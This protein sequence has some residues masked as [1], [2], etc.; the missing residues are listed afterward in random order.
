M[1][2][3]RP[4]GLLAAL[5]LPAL[6]A[7]SPAA[8][9]A[10]AKESI[11]RIP[12]TWRTHDEHANRAGGARGDLLAAV[13]ATGRVD[14]TPAPPPGTGA[15]PPGL[16]RYG[17]VEAGPRRLLVALGEAVGN[18]AVDGIARSL[19]AEPGGPE[20]HLVGDAAAPRSILEAVR[21][22]RLAGRAV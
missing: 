18:Q 21:E 22:G 15:V 8:P 1:P 19:G 4:V 3:V 10:G 16:L 14:L 17:I 13:Q 9:E 2:R 7:L 5:A 6:V 20:V 12:T 11:L